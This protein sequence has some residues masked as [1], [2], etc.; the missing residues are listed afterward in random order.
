MATNPTLLTMPIAENGTKNTIP[1]TTTTLGRMSQDQG[2]PAETS[3]PLAA[4]GVAPSR[5]DFNGAFNL[6][7]NINFYAQKGWQFL[8]DASQDYYAGCI[9]RDAT[10]GQLYECITDVAAGGSAPSADTTH[11]RVSEKVFYFDSV[12]D[13]RD[14]SAVV[15]GMM[16]MTK[17]YYAANDGGTATYNIR[18]AQP[19]DVDDGGSIIVLDNGNVAE[20]ITNG[21]VNVKQFGAKG[22]GVTDDTTAVKNAVA[23]GYNLFLPNGTYLVNDTINLTERTGFSLVGEDRNHTF[24][25]CGADVTTLF[26]LIGG[27]NLLFST[28][29]IFGTNTADHAFVIGTAASG[30]YAQTA[31]SSNR[32]YNMRVER[33]SKSNASAFY[34]VKGWY[35]KISNCTI[36]YSNIGIGFDDNAL[37]TTLLIDRQTRISANAYGVKS[38]SSDAIISDISFENCVFESNTQYAVDL[39][40]VKALISIDGCYLEGNANGFK[41]SGRTSD[42]DKIIASINRCSLQDYPAGGKI[43]EIAYGFVYAKDTSMSIEDMVQGTQGIIRFENISANNAQALLS[44]ARTYLPGQTNIK[45]ISSSTGATV[46]YDSRGHIFD[47]HILSTSVKPTISINSNNLQGG[48]AELSDDSTDACGTIILTPNSGETMKL[49]TQFVKIEFAK[50][51]I[52]NPV[53]VVTVSNYSGAMTGLHVQHVSGYEK[54]WFRVGISGSISGISDTIRINYVVMGGKSLAV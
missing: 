32:F 43:L 40:N 23:S 13:M 45:N 17:G 33:F 3:L 14:A 35:N 41:F 49:Y 34:F 46:Y 5:A 52:Y 53:V 2:F 37:I 8:F 26:S 44:S 1:T 28:V 47:S 16:V 51:Y 11:W 12:A 38:V 42:Y 19:G 9:V 36:G 6:L 50:A 54:S 15:P 27:G 30:S 18:A 10:D 25:Q 7:S 21:V 22:D 20:L 24:I 31:C 48:T 29:C 4:G 39:E